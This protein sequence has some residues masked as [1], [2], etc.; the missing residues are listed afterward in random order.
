MTAKSVTEEMQEDIENNLDER[1]ASAET[2]AAEQFVKSVE[3]TEKVDKAEDAAAEAA[4]LAAL[5]A[6]SQAKQQES[7][8]ASKIVAKKERSLKFGVVGTGQ[9]G[10]RLGECFFQQ[11]YPAVAINTA[12]MDLKH[13]QIP[14]SNKLLL[15]YGLGGASKD[16]EI[17]KAAAETHRDAIKELITDKLGD[18]QVFVLCTS[19]GGGSGAGSVETLVD[20][21][22]EIGKPIIVIAALPMSNEDPMTKSNSLETLAKIAKMAQTNRVSNLVVVDNSKIEVIYSS[23]GQM[24]FFEVANKAIVDPIDA[25]NTLSSLPSASK[26]L[27]PMELTKILL[28]SPGC[29][30]YGEMTV[31]NYQ[32]DTTLAEAIINNLD[33]N[34]LSEG[35][36]LKEAKY[37][38]VIFAAPKHVWDKLPASSVNYAMSMVNDRVNCLGVFKGLYTIES[39]EDSVKVYSIFSGLGLPVSRVQSL[40]K[41]TESLMSSNKEKESLRTANLNLDLGKDKTISES[42]KIRQK[43]QN[44][45]STFGKFVGSTVTDRRK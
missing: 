11:G 8:M 37:C 9:G 7:K 21:M 44:K 10:S 32:E 24:N 17:G 4:K 38:G 12:S 19:L 29:T 2:Q 41:E 40:Q 23:V 3:K 5:R 15:E 1:V 33:G 16:L 20:I 13:I 42:E 28:D 30:V 35:F 34:L 14:D 39:E 22:G 36:S 6:K 27:D 45:S 43:I 25:F 31:T 26:A 18:S